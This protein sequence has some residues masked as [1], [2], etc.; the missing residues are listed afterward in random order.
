MKLPSVLNTRPAGVVP[1]TLQLEP[2]GRLSL[3]A[4]V[5]DSVCPA[6]TLKASACG[7]GLTT[8]ATVAVA[9]L[10]GAAASQTR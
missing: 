2:A 6:A 5:F 1:C 9:Q 7:T 8:T 10:L 4:T 3:P